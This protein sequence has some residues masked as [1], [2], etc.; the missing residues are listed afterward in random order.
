MSIS[1]LVC[2]CAAAYA[3]DGQPIVVDTSMR[4]S[5]LDIVKYLALL[6]PGLAVASAFWKKLNQINNAIDKFPE[7]IMKIESIHDRLRT[8]EIR[9]ELDDNASSGHH[10]RT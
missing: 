7:I 9:R 6:S 2:S 8:L 4:M 3:A 1:A 5:L 10:D